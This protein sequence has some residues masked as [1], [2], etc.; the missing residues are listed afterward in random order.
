MAKSLPRL[1]YLMLKVMITRKVL[2]TLTL[3]AMLFNI[4]YFHVGTTTRDFSQPR[5]KLEYLR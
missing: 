3:A 4:Y 5:P 2:L 1:L